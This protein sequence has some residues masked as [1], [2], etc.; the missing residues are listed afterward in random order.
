MKKLILHIGFNKTGS[1]SIQQNLALNADRLRDR[2]ILYP[3]DP[4]APYTQR[5]QHVPLAAAVPGNRIGW[6][7]PKKAKTKGAAWDSLSRVLDASACDTLILSSEGFG[8]MTM[9][10]PQI[11]WLQ[12]RFS[13]YDITVI[14]YIRRQDA[15]L[16]SAYQQRIKAGGTARFDFKMHETMPALRFD[17]RLA[18]W[19]EAFGAQK[20][21]VRPFERRFWP[22]GE[23]CFD[24]LET[25]DAD[26]RGITPAS[27]ANDGLDYRAVELMRQLNLKNADTRKRDKSGFHQR[28]KTYLALAKSLEAYL[29]DGFEKQKLML[30]AE[31]ANML[32][33]HYRDSNEAALAGT[34]ISADDFFPP[35]PES[36]EA[37]LP[38]NR[39]PQR[40]LLQ[41]TAAL[42]AAEPA[43]PLDTK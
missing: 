33:R 8:G 22:E 35:V 6:L 20:V 43:T 25:I 7:S 12:E 19:R 31:E 17:R 39:L 30:S 36:R 9:K 16:L 28:R 11:R 37:R 38:P 29:P 13:G 24:F 18:L 3:Y 1:T 32:R 23:L 10:A 21:I 14:N 34:G 2:G 27:P 4:A 26:R 15:Y 41:L 5:W 40:M 42:A